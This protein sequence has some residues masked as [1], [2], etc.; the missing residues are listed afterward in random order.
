MISTGESEN[1]IKMSRSRKYRLCFNLL[2]YIAD[3]MRDYQSA[4][5]FLHDEE[6]ENEAHIKKTPFPCNIITTLRAPCHY[7]VLAIYGTYLDITQGLSYA[8]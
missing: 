7:G 5:V 8:D 6:G 3:V 1:V 2:K 4:F